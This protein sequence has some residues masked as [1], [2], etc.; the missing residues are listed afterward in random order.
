L[1]LQIKLAN[2]FPP[3]LKNLVEAACPLC[4]D[5][6]SLQSNI[7]TEEAH[8]DDLAR[9]LCMTCSPALANWNDEEIADDAYHACV[10]EALKCEEPA[11]YAQKHAALLE[12][13]KDKERDMSE[14]H[15]Q[16]LLDILHCLKDGDVRRL[17]TEYKDEFPPGEGVESDPTNWGEYPPDVY[18]NWISTVF[19]YGDSRLDGKILVSLQTVMKASGNHMAKRLTASIY[20]GLMHFKPIQYEAIAWFLTIEEERF[21]IH[22]PGGFDAHLRSMIAMCLDATNS[23]TNSYDAEFMIRWML[24][25]ACKNGSTDIFSYLPLPSKAHICTPS[26][27]RRFLLMR[28]FLLWQRTPSSG[29]ETPDWITAPIY[30]TFDDLP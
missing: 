25:F 2:P 5:T 23:C 13:I 27:T 10:S 19:A 18:V 28:E 7:C 26:L 9:V 22:A 8:K 4:Q 17:K 24:V 12:R 15:L 16:K 30:G 29:E 11:K 20:R 6:M 1:A 3:A 14:E 21:I